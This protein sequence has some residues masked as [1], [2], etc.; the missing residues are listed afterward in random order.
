M[1]QG[2][3][4]LTFFNPLAFGNVFLSWWFLRSLTE[5]TTNSQ[6]LQ[7]S[8]LKIC[9]CTFSFVQALVLILDYSILHI[10]SMNP[11]RRRSTGWLGQRQPDDLLHAGTHFG[12]DW[13]H[14]VSPVLLLH[15]KV[16]YYVQRGSKRV[17]YRLQWR[18]I[19]H[20]NLMSH[21]F[22]LLLRPE[23]CVIYREKRDCLAVPL[24]LARRIHVTVFIIY[25]IINML[26]FS[27]H[28]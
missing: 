27:L 25:M 4:K 3:A 26:V 24:R 15:N 14:I 12:W 5:T 22:M 21:K 6:R 9:P 13:N 17:P 23:P 28:H 11:V 7:Y 16:V 8:I 2:F 19:Y 20:W 1:V 18:M 10:L